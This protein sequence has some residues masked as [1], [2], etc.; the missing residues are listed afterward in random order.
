MIYHPHLKKIA[1]EEHWATKDYQEYTMALPGFGNFFRG[2]R[3]VE[4]HMADMWKRLIDL[5]GNRLEEMDRNGIDMQVLSLNPPGIQ[6]EPDAD[7]AVNMARRYNDLLAEVIARHPARFAGLAVLPMQSPSKA[8]EEL[9]R[10]VQLGIN[11]AHVNNHTNGEY[12]DDPKFRTVLE[13]AEAL[14]IPLCIHP[15]SPVEQ[16]NVYRG[17]PELMGPI[18]G[19]GVEAASHALRLVFSGIFEAFPKLTIVL[20]HLGEML[21]FVLKRLDGRWKRFGRRDSK[22][23]KPPSRYIKEHFMVSTSG[24][25]SPE[26]LILAVLTMGAERILFAVDYPY[27]SIGEGVAFIDNVPISDGDREKICHLNAK[28]IFKL[29][30]SLAAD[31]S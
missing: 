19:W 25:F 16:P 23:S 28:R 29:S 31:A 12:L 26:S 18:W 1:V 4:A 3:G 7:K 14:D 5:D 30:N 11:G 27:E 10:A 13:R 21:P 20:G 15:S 8:A 9:E 24:I 6:L 2:N 17:Y 22:M